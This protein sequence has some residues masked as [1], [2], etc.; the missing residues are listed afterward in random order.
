MV[1]IVGGGLPTGSGPRPWSHLR[2]RKIERKAG[3]RQE[4]HAGLSDAIS[5]NWG[6][7]IVNG[8][9][10]CDRLEESYRLAVVIEGSEV[11][12]LVVG[13]GGHGGQN[14][15]GWG[16]IL[17]SLGLKAY[18]LG[19]RV[20]GTRCTGHVQDVGLFSGIPR[21]FLGHNVQAMSG[22]RPGYGGDAT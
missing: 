17:G 3:I 6:L 13:S 14:A 8:D 12:L 18:G 9:H 2:C 11:V 19:F 1:V 7:Q 21:Q 20:S 4:A 15:A 10:G 22:T 5:I 16:S